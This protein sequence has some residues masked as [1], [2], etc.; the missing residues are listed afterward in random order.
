MNEPAREIAASS[1]AGPEAFRRE[2]VEGCR[3]VILRALVSDWP[4]VLAGGR[5]P[6]A[7]KEYVLQFDSGGQ[8]EAFIGDPDIAGKYYYSADLRG[9]NFQRRR[10]SF[11]GAL[12]AIVSTVGR[13]DGASVY[14]G[15]VPIDECLPGFSTQ[16]PLAVLPGIAARIWLGH[17][18]NVS[19]HYDTFDNVACVVAGTRRFT[20]FPPEAIADLYVGPIDYTMAGQPVSL[21]ASA[22]A[23]DERFPRFRKVKEQALVA[24]LNPGDAM[25]IP[26]LWWHQ[27]EATASFNGLVNYWWDAFSI[28][29]DAPATGLL[30]SMIT[31]A[32]RPPQER[33]A[34]KAFFD[35]YVF[36]SNGHPLAHLPAD[37]HGVLGPLKPHNYGRIRARLMRLLR[38]K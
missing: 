26:K 2:V 37:Q 11:A 10:M 33:R 6:A 38:G 32:E 22:P 27:V 8:V 13:P 36:R 18:S 17:A 15:S 25:Y 23:D 3:P 35:Y 28:G 14:L 12:D 31:I 29:S 5:S 24:E 1:L 21:A 34:W 9:F 4:V 30:L 7:F 19:A 20:F 16:N